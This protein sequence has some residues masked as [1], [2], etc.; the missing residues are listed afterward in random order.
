MFNMFGLLFNCFVSDLR[1]GVLLGFDFVAD[2]WGG[3]RVYV[4]V[5]YIK[6]WFV[7]WICLVVVYLVVWFGGL[8]LWFVG[9]CSLLCLLRWVCIFV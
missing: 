3:L 2:A 7:V 1:S 9:C 8:G 5:C 4:V 6:F